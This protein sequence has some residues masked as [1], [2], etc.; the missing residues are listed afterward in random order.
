MS[1]VTSR[2]TIGRPIEDVFA[3]LTDVEKTGLWYPVDVEEHWTSPPPLGVGS[4]RHAVVRMGG[5]RSENDAVVT[6]YD[7]PL[8]AAIAGTSPNVPFVST[9]VFSREGAATLVEVTTEFTFRG[10]ARIAGPFFARWFGRSWARG[11]ATLKRMME[12]GE[13]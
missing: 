3:I 12:S 11:L 10:A 8:R 9:L 2:I 7:P 1:S 6:E 13:L 4:T 5:R